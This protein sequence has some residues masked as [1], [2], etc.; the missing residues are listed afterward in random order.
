[1]KEVLTCLIPAGGEGTRLKPHT[2]HQQKPMFLM[3]RPDQRI[4]DFSLRSSGS[5]DH[6]LVT[7][8]YRA[9]RADIVEDYVR[10]YPNVA[11]LRDLRRI[12]AA[13]LIDHYDIFSQED[14]GGDLVILPGDHVH[15]HFSLIDF[16]RHHRDM[17]TD[18]TLLVTPQK[19]YGE[20]VTIKNGFAK[21]VVH[22]PV[23]GCLS[24]TGVYMIRNTYIVDWMRRELKMGWN[25]EP[26]N[27]YRDI[28]CPAIENGKVAIF[29][30]PDEG[31]CDD[32]GT[33]KRYHQN[34]MRLS[35][36]RNV[37]S[38]E[39]RIDPDVSVV[40]CVI[41]GNP[42]ID[43]GKLRKAI[44]SGSDKDIAITGVPNG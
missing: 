36:G 9:E 5:G 43:E 18:L 26:R 2:L 38:R 16:Q 42:I 23:P 22:R 39:A 3:G 17:G 33:I 1:M 11:V 7:T 19:D 41:L 37:I 25:G 24:T 10:R 44:V 30:L 29:G 15:E 32:A 40:C 35:G 21:K 6:T 13:S 12:G 8:N 20:Y 4:I 27:M 28:I 14:P 34:N 31:Y